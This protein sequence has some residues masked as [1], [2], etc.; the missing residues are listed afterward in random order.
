M[1]T[2]FG[3]A[4]ERLHRVGSAHLADS[5]GAYLDK[6][7]AVLAEDLELIVDRDVERVDMANGM[8]DRAVMVTVRSSL[9]QPLDRKGAFLIDGKKLHFDGVASDDGH[10]ISLYVRP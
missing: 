9:I 8:I 2:R 4:L 7:G 1:S 6:T 10:M 5:L 3:R